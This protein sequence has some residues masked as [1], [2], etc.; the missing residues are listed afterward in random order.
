MPPRAT[1][2]AQYAHDKRLPEAFL[3]SLGLSDRKLNALTSGAH[4]LPRRDRQRGLQRDRIA[5]SGDKFRWSKGSRLLLYGLDRLDRNLRYV[6]LVEGESDAQTSVVPQ[7]ARVGVPGAA[8]WK[9]E[10]AQLLT[11]LTVYVW[12]EP[13]DAGRQF[14]NKVTTAVPTGHIITAPP[15]RKDVSDCHLN[16]DDV[17]ALLEKLRASAQDARGF[18]AAETRAA[19][20]QAEQKAGDLLDAPDILAEFV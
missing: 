12:Q 13:D 16:G 11:G 4:S 7:G 15:G 6:N 18:A 17:P 20:E 9:A 8:T 2:L 19:I 3:R 14:V 5:A 10:W 1:L